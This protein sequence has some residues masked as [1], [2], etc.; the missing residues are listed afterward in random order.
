M[1]KIKIK[2]REIRR[3]RL[4]FVA[5][6]LLSYMLVFMILGMITVFAVDRYFYKGARE[7][8]Q[9]EARKLEFSSFLLTEN[10]TNYRKMVLYFDENGRMVEGTALTY[11][12]TRI[13]IRVVD[14]I[15]QEVFVSGGLEKLEHHY[16]TLL[17][18]T[19]MEDAPYAKI[20]LNI[21][22]EYSA[23]NTVITVYLIC[24]VSIFILS[25]AASYMM[26]SRTIK[27]IVSNLEKQLNFVSDA[28]HELRTPLAI[29]Q[30]K[31]ENILTDSNKTVYEV[32]EDLA[33]SLKELNRLTKLTSDLL[34][35]ARDDQQRIDLNLEIININQLIKETIEPFEEIAEIQEKKFVY[36][37]QDVNLKVDKNKIYQLLII[38]LDNALTYT[39]AGDGIHIDLSAYQNEILIEVKDTGI[40]INENSL[41]KVFERFYRE[42]KARNRDTGGN[43]LGLSIAKTIVTHHKGRIMAEVNYPKGTVFK[44]YLPKMK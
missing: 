11:I 18:R 32:S 5:Y 1:K 24:V 21:D 9:R 19:N 41:D 31:L 8:I 40:G 4:V 25:I 42:D 33:V 15:R 23:R 29:I 38:L 30:S 13:N 39:N 3:Q 17:V 36:S 14:V 35:L 44:V 2:D 43:G 34:V 10:D 16:L 6:N 28:S 7:E 37:G 12:P 20:Y 27:P 26:S 22:G